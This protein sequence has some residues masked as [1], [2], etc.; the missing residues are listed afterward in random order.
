MINI[1]HMPMI[2][3]TD[4]IFQK[5][6][7]DTNIKNGQNGLARPAC[8][9]PAY[10]IL[11]QWADGICM[12][13]YNFLALNHDKAHCKWTNCLAL[14]SSLWMFLGILHACGMETLG[15]MLVSHAVAGTTCTDCS[16]SLVNGNL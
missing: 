6:F 10:C 11:P 16:F 9:E 14:V 13:R 1:Q 2:A 8:W 7:W 5:P 3:I 4:K 12:R 15:W